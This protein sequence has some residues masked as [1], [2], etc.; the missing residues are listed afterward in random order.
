MAK[1]NIDFEALKE[2]GRV[3]REDYGMGGAVQHGASTLPVDLFNHFV[4]HGAIEVHLATALM[5]T[6]YRHVPL[7]LK[8]EI[9]AGWTNI[10][11]PSARPT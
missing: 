11:S 6:F 10:T 8:C 5:T 1:I 4:K 9:F 3:A 7:E 2:L